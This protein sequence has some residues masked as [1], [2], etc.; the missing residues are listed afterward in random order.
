MN[1]DDFDRVKVSEK[2]KHPLLLSAGSKEHCEELFAAIK[3]NNPKRTEIV[4]L[5]GCN[6]GNGMYKQIEM[7][8]Q[9]LKEFVQKCI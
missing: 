2:R 8:Q 1:V 5:R 6:H 4:I 3:S 9:A 7:Y